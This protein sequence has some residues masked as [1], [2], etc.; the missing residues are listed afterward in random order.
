MNERSSAS[1]DQVSA[2]LVPDSRSAVATAASESDDTPSTRARAGWRRRSTTQAN[3][4]DHGRAGERDALIAV[5]VPQRPHEQQREADSGEHE[6]ARERIEVRRPETS[7]SQ[8]PAA[9]TTRTNEATTA[10]VP[11]P[12][13]ASASSAS[14]QPDSDDAADPIS[15]LCQ[16]RGTASAT[17]AL[18]MITANATAG[19]ES[20]VSI[21]CRAGASAAPSSPIAATVSDDHA[22]AITTAS[23][24]RPPASGSATASGTSS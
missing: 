24:A 7:C 19:H 2:R 18:K 12:A 6:R 21:A 3:G 20:P 23:A 1:A 22:I 10:V 16:R 13:E 14:R 4:P 11:A 8:I 17:V 5:D 15:S 9:S